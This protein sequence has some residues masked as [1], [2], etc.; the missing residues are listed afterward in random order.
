M[1]KILKALFIFAV[2]ISLT[3]CAGPQ[4]PKEKE[5]LHG[6]GFNT[7]KETGGGY[8]KSVDNHS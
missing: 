5:G 1:N 8:V 7:I 4:K 6:Y 2:F 3:G